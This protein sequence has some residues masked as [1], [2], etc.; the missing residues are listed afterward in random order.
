MHAIKL[1]DRVNNVDL[2]LHGLLKHVHKHLVMFIKFLFIN[3][4][5]Y[6]HIIP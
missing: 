1:A 3:D 5:N 2:F 6:I 4:N